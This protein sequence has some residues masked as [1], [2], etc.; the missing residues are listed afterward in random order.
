MDKTVTQNVSGTAFLVNVSR[1]KRVE[2][3]KDVYA[4]LWITPE[5]ISLWDEF[6]AKAYP[7]DDINLSLRNRFFLEHLKGFIANN[8][9]GVFINIASGFTN[10]PFLIDGD[11]KFVEIDLPNIIGFKRDKTDQWMAENK[12]PRRKIEFIS[13]DLNDAL[14]RK[15]IHKALGTII[16]NRPSFVIMEGLTYY[17]K[18]EVLND[19]FKMLGNIQTQDSLT[20]FDYWRPDAMEYPAMLRLKKYLGEK[21]GRSADNWNLFDKSYINQLTDYVEIE[22]VENKDYELIHSTTRKLQ[23]REN[24]IPDFYSVLKRV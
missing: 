6:A 11:C 1:S 21:F 14:Q 22:S 19:I 3:S 2:I 5:S 9:N 20:A 10:Y 18:E 17:L 24:K 8:E 4:H 16:G 12:L 7:N 15:T 13:A 23:G